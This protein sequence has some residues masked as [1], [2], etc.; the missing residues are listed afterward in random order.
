MIAWDSKVS[1]LRGRWESAAKNREREESCL[2]KAQSDVGNVEQA[3][4]IVQRVA[5]MIQQQAHEQIA[6]VVSRCMEAVFAEPYEFRIAFEQ[7]RG[8]TEAVL[9]FVRNGLEVDPMTAS[10]GG[11]VDVASFALRLACLMM[12]RPPRRRVLILDE[13]FRFVSR[14]LRTRV[15][16][17]L[18]TLAE[19]M[20]MQFVVVTHDEALTIGRV[21]ELAC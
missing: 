19:E 15:K 8:K 21:V 17:M 7:K 4:K 9:T 2:V 13:P 6:S 3:Q 12:S 14:D 11:V 10:G 5:Q 16:Q 18:L 20:K 1:S